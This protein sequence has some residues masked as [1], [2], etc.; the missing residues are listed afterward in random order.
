MSDRYVIGPGCDR[1]W[2]GLECSGVRQGGVCVCGSATGSEHCLRPWVMS[3]PVRLPVFPHCGRIRIPGLATLPPGL[4]RLPRYQVTSARC[5]SASSVCFWEK[6]FSGS[7]THNACWK[8]SVRSGAVC[9]AAGTLPSWPGSLNS[10]LNPVFRRFCRRCKKTVGWIRSARDAV[11]GNPVLHGVEAGWGECDHGFAWTGWSYA[12]TAGTTVSAK[13][14][15]RKCWS[16]QDIRPGNITIVLIR[17]GC[18]FI[19]PDVGGSASGGTQ[20]GVL[21]FHLAGRISRGARYSAIG[22]F[23]RVSEVAGTGCRPV[24]REGNSAAFRE[25]AWRFVNI[26]LRALVALGSVRIMPKFYVMSPISGN[27]IR[28]IRCR[29][30][31]DNYL[32]CLPKSRMRRTRW[33]SRMC[34]V[35]C[36]VIR[37]LWLSGQ[38]ELALSS[39]KGKKIY[40]PIL[41]GLRS[42]IRYDR[43]YFDK[44]VASAAVTGKTDYRKT[45]A[46]L[47]P[48]YTNMQD[49][50]PIFDWQQVIRKKRDCICRAGCV[51][52]CGSGGSGG[53]SMFAIWSR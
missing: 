53:N 22:R 40:D 26:T 24:I 27:S 3:P 8:P 50:R 37:K 10:V 41:D 25:F 34:P 13:P 4:R 45:A 49:P 6:G 17:K 1:P 12:G 43:T 48:D 29:W 18:G 15:W 19:A 36:K 32:I 2:G 23:G 47:S 52:G 11:G 28:H 21:C 44:I 7:K 51:I 14:V 31:K 5:R 39:E 42:A 30:L 9:S 35:I 33:R 16:L 46:L 38:Q 20:W